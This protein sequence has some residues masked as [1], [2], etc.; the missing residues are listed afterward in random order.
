VSVFEK[1]VLCLLFILHLSMIRAASPAAVPSEFTLRNCII[2]LARFAASE[3][4]SQRKARAYR[5]LEISAGD[6]AT[7]G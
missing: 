4:T 6:A 1:F 5:A 7:G 3:T 2:H